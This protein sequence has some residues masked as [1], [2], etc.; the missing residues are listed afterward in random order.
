MDLIVALHQYTISWYLSRNSV[1][2]QRLI[3]RNNWTFNNNN[4][5]RGRKPVAKDIQ[6]L[7]LRIK[8]ENIL[9]GVRKVQGE[10]GKL[11]ICIDY[12]TVWNILRNF[13][14]K[15]KVTKYLDWKKFLTMQIQNIYAMDFFTIDT[16]I[17][18]R[19]YVFFIISHTT[20]EII[21]YAVTENPTKEFVR[22]QIIEFE[23]EIN[24]V[25]Y[26]IHDNA[27]Q[28]YLD[29]LSYG[30]KEVRIS[31]KASNMNAIAERFVRNAR[32]EAFDYFITFQKSIY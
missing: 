23:Q 8:N 4:K 2:W 25:V 30:I 18:K 14:R 6:D 13:R 26:L 28:F 31:V 19:Y 27:C 16:I 21:R 9:W 24:R 29:F 17:N 10:L 22:Q 15:G 7:I 20:R 12:K 11:G 1:K 32:Q 5:K 3:I